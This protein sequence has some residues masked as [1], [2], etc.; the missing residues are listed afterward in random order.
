M[1]NERLKIAVQKSG[2][3]TELSLH[4]L[5]KCGISLEK[6]K[7]QLLCKAQNFP[8]DVLLVRD[9]DIPAFVAK[10]VCQL[11]IIGQNVLFEKQANANGNFSDIASVLEFGFGKCRLSLAVPNDVSYKNTSFFENKIIATSYKG[12]LTQY[13]KEQGISAKIVTMQGAVEIAPK[14]HLADAIC[15]LVST[16]STLASNGLKEVEI[17][18][19]SQAVLIKNADISS[20]L[21]EIYE[22]LLTRMKA[23][24]KAQNSRYIMLHSSLKAL[25]DI[26]AVL[27]GSETPTIVPLQG[28]DDKVAVHA[29]CDEEIFW[30]TM[31]A[32]KANGASSILVLPIE[33]MLD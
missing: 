25:D 27:P 23:V 4:L 16:G 14:M 8:L 13:L 31:E 29:V 26:K 19:Q 20:S 3:L 21:E 7:D 28:Y 18:Q 10:D 6:S 5:E 22:R 2:R 12:V 32:L 1:T 17:L 15:D 11:G 33:K 30:N 9:D 24:L